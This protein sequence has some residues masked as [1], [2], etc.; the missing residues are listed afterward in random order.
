MVTPVAQNRT[1][2]KGNTIPSQRARRWCYT[3]N[4]PKHDYDAHLTHMFK[5]DTKGFAFGYE[6]GETGTLHIQGYI[7][8][9]NPKSLSATKKWLGD[10]AH[11]EIAKFNRMTNV[12]YCIKDKGNL[13]KWFTTWES[14]MDRRN[15]VI[16]EN[17]QNI[18]WK[19]WQ[20]EILILCEKL[21]RNRSIYFYIDREGNKGK[22]FLTKYIYCKYNCL[23]CN[24]KCNDILNGVKTYMDT[25]KK[26][27]DIVIVDIPKCSDGH[28]S[29]AAIEMLKNGLAYSGKYEGGIILL[30]KSPLVI[31]FTND[32]PNMDKFSKDRYII[33]YL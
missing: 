31:I 17:Y 32:E 12:N 23:I 8:W 20:N 15:K 26:D 24:G 9:A 5:L 25:Y 29:Y 2:S 28:F 33:K 16:I 7:E 13:K 11:V 6:K 18:K 4:N 19:N 1:E 27:P 22:S 30:N 10:N 14:H 3:I 21:E